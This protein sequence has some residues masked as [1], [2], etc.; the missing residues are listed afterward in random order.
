MKICCAHIERSLIICVVHSFL[1]L[2]AIIYCFIS[3]TYYQYNNPKSGQYL[4]FSWLPCSY[5]KVTPQR[6]LS[7]LVK[8]N[9]IISTEPHFLMPVVGPSGCG[10]TL[11][12]ADLLVY[13][14]RLFRPNFDCITY[15]FQHWQP[16]YDDI[17]SKL[18]HNEI[19]FLN[20]VDWKKL[21]LMSNLKRHLLVFDDVFDELANSVEFFNLVVSGRHKNQHVIFLKHNLH[22]KKYKLKDN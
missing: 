13:H 14:R 8:M 5:S 17:A 16:V 22:Q 4:V 9:K 21:A 10:K 18:N 11:L 19:N 1:L 2:I 20:G 15:I 6:R 3:I 12:V 7:N